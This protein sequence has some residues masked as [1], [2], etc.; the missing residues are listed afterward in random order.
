MKKY[1]LFLTLI[2][3]SLNFSQERKEIEAKRFK[4]PPIIDGILDDLQWNNL[5]PAKNFE[6]WQP[7]NGSSE[8]K[9]YENFVYM[10]YDDDNI[11]F[12][13]KF[14]NLNP[15]PVEFS[16]RDNIWE[17]NAETF[18]LSINPYDDNINYQGFQVTSAGTLGDTYTSEDITPEDWDFDTVFEAKVKINNDNWSMEMKIP[19]SAL[20]FPSKKVQDWA[21]NF[22]RKIVETGEVY[23]WNFVDQA[24][25]KYP[26]SMGITKGIKDIS[27]PLRLFFYPYGQT[28]V[29]FSKG[30][31]PMNAYS[32]GMDVKYGINNS[33]TLDATLIPDFGQV[34]FDDK[35]LNLSPFEQ[36][37]DENRAFFTEGA[38]LFK[39]ADGLGFRGGSFFYSRRIGDEISFNKDEYIKE[40]ESLINYDAKPELLNSIK[41][42]GTTNSKLSIGFINSITNKAYARFK[43]S[44]EEIRKQLIA[45]LTNYNILLLS[46]QVLNDYSTISIANTNVNRGKDFDNANNTAL[47]FDLF[48]SNRKYNFKAA[49]YQSNSKSFSKTKGFRGG[50][51][52]NEITGNFRFGLGWTGVDAHYYQN[53]LGY[54][55]NRNDQRLFSRIRYQTFESTKSFEKISAYLALSTRSRFYPKLLKS[56]GGRIG[57]NFT[58]KK[59]EEFEFDIDY[60]SQY[61]NFDEPRKENVYIIDPEEYEFSFA[62][63]SDKRKKFTY[64]FDIQRSFAVNEDFDENKK[65]IK[66]GFGFL[67][68]LNNKLNLQYEIGNSKNNDNVGYIFSEEDEIFFGKRDVKSIENDVSINYNFDSYKSINIKFRQFWSTAKYNDSFYS[69]NDNGKRSISNKDIEDYDPNTNFNLWNFDLGFNWEYAPGSKL[70]LLYRN[71]IFNQDN[72]SGISYFTST[73]ELFE[74]PINH[75]L[76]IRINYFID[77]NLLK[78]IRT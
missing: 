2:A 44:N 18:F 27:P 45:P 26:E 22:G 75:Q 77:Y 39:K 15:I 31:S 14:N 63:M 46:K 37:F 5:S 23:T 76:S 11:Y 8:K 64:G 24:N 52:I 72:L 58:T 67:Y 74:N 3:C 29:D 16:Q 73:K 66:Y 42:T 38:P 68:R 47:I 33:F 43:N 54:Y 19:Y 10:G 36:E 20:R 48:D 69:L 49:V 65:G 41:I 21:I 34:T 12:A 35:E 53:D 4:S 70:T 55:N 78:R 59:L 7:N 25:K 60:T 57:F 62:Y 71:N 40:N 17:V 50:I 51:D 30:N 6:R 13:G 1:I 9:G 28:S 61:K 56:N 32:A